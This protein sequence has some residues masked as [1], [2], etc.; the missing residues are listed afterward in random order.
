M[1]DTFDLNYSWLKTWKEN[2]NPPTLFYGTTSNLIHEIEEH[3]LGPGMEEENSLMAIAHHILSSARKLGNKQIVEQAELILMEHGEKPGPLKLTFNYH[4]ALYLAKKKTRRLEALQWLCET[5]REKMGQCEDPD[6]IELTVGRLSYSC[7]GMCDIHLSSPGVVVYV[8]TNLSKF[9]NLP[10]LLEDK[11]ELKRALK[12]KSSI[13]RNNWPKTS[14]WKKL[15]S[16][17]VERCLEKSIRGDETHPGLG[18]EV[19]TLRT[20]PLS[21]IVRIE[22][23]PETPAR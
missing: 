6:L 19:F 15:T 8:C 13:S 11:K 2:P 20:I 14:W 9:R 16:S 21:D 1:P 5:F 17:E 10:P 22:L 4:H 23:P 3:G 7:G 12:G 18:Q